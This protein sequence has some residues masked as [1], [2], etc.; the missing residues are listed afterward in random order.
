MMASVI[1]SWTPVAASKA[2]ALRPF[3]PMNRFLTCSFETGTTAGDGRVFGRVKKSCTSVDCLGSLDVFCA[4]VTAS[5]IRS[6][7][8]RS[9]EMR[10]ESARLAIS[11]F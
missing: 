4:L 10:F 11:R 7:L 9:D 3:E 1:Y 8:M 5:A 2:S 6:G